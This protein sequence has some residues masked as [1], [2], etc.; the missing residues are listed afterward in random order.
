M[1]NIANLLKDEITRL[2][3]KVV[4][5]QTGDLKSTLSAQRKQISALKKQVAELERQVKRLGKSATNSA[6]PETSADEASDTRFQARGLRSL[7][8][9]LGLSAQDFAKLAG[10]SAQSIYNWETEKSSP[11]ASQVQA[12]AGLRGMG[13]KE[14]AARL[15]QLA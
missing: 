6:A 1:P 14:A 10:V 11:R 15:E 13:K 5:E 8:A 3:K 12:L 7:R 2:S 4:K 9:R